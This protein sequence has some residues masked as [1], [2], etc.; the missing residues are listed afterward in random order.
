MT[1]TGDYNPKGGVGPGAVRLAKFI[2]SQLD[3]TGLNLQCSETYA[4]WGT[5]KNCPGS[6]HR[7]DHADGIRRR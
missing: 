2:N 4:R 3:A 5:G 7:H 1:L 6:L